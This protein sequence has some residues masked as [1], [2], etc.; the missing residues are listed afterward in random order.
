M[1]SLILWSLLVVVTLKYLVLVMRADNEGEGGILALAAL[2]AP[3]AQAS[4]RRSGVI[5]ALGLFGAALL[6]V[7]MTEIWHWPRTV[8]ALM[9][10]LLTVD[11]A[12]FTA[13]IVKIPASGWF[14]LL[15]GVVMVVV[16]LTWTKGRRLVVDS[17]RARSASFEELFAF[18]S[19]NTSGVTVSCRLPPRPRGR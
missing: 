11:L 8:V 19:R 13:N 6:Y 9:L 1:L 14:P 15:I 7:A 12:Y 18:L 5:A 16:M 2:V 3:T 10:L 4:G 17:I